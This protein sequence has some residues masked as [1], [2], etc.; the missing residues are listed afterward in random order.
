[1]PTTEQT[2]DEVLSLA[3]THFKV[4]RERLA[5]DLE[6][7]GRLAE[8]GFLPHLSQPG[9]RVGQGGRLAYRRAGGV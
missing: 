3:A 5:P 6:A 7:R 1:M 4:P 2:L 8:R 9:R